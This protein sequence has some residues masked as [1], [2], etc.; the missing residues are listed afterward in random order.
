MG[1]CAAVPA[2][3]T[4]WPARTPESA[5]HGDV[6]AYWVLDP[7]LFHHLVDRFHQLR[8]VLAFKHVHTGHAQPE[9]LRG[10]DGCALI[11]GVQRNRLGFA[12][13]VDVAAELAAFGAAAHGCDDATTDDKRAHVGASGFFD[14]VLNQHVLPRALQRFDNGFGDF[15]AVGQNHAD[16]LRALKQFDDYRRAADALNGGHHA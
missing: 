10:H 7:E 13:P 14:E 16:A 4:S 15:V 12:A 8:A 6:D 1:I 2:Y 9:N 3:V 11:L 5:R